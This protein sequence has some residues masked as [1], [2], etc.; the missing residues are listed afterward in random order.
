MGNGKENV[1][2][3]KKNH[4]NTFSVLFYKKFKDLTV[5]RYQQNDSLFDKMFKDE[6]FMEENVASIHPDRKIFLILEK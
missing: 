5:K 4:R 2:F 6:D 1:R 3:A